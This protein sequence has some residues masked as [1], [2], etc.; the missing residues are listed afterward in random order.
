MDLCWLG[1]T[2]QHAGGPDLR[3]MGGWLKCRF[4]CFLSH[5]LFG[6]ALRLAVACEPPQ[7]AENDSC[8]LIQISKGVPNAYDQNPWFRLRELQTAGV[9]DRT[10]RQP[11]G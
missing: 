9:V 1:S 7:C 6:F 5:R 11:S 2:L 3:C 10:C 8:P 4:G